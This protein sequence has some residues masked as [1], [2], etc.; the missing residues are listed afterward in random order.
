MKVKPNIYKH[1]YLLNISPGNQGLLSHQEAQG[2]WQE[3]HLW[4]F[5]FR[6]IL[7]NFKKEEKLQAFRATET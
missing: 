6:Q 1:L 5:R 4:Q 7:D 3:T 2:E